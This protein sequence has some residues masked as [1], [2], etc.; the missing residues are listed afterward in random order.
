MRRRGLDRLSFATAPALY[1]AVWLCG[2]IVLAGYQWIAPATLIAAILLLALL[3]LMATRKAL[4]VALLPLAGAWLTLGM[5]LSEIEPAPDP[6]KQLSVIA[7]AGEATA[8]HGEVTRT[9]PIRITQSTSPF[10]AAVREEQSESFD[11]RVASADG[12][13]VSGGL[14]A[15][16]Y[17]PADQPFP[18]IHCGDQIETKIAMHLPERYLDPGVWDATA[19]LR[20]QGI[21]VVG[22]LKASA[23]TLT[24]TRGHGGFHCWLHAVQ[25]AGSQRLIAFAGSSTASRLPRWMLLSESDAGMLS[26]MILGDR[27]YLDHQARVGFERTGSFHLL[28]VSGMHLAIFAG[29]I[30]SLVAWLRLPRVVYSRHHWLLFRLRLTGRLRGTGAAVFLD[31]HPVP[32][33]AFAVPGTQ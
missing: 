22:S 14:R 33:G 2:G 20:Q 16:A 4:R 5:L 13:P 19:W 30:F 27:T 1:A 15:T 18:A 6:Q 21:G 10:G 26:A 11:V 24:P 29:C 12:R 31:G 17:A 9:T 23:L 28:V 32:P 7:D 25:Q 8:V 3:S